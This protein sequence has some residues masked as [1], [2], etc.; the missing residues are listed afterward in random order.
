MRQ[1]LRAAVL[2]FVGIALC[3]DASA[4]VLGTI[5]GTAKDASGA[6]LPGV[7]VEVSS[8]ALI[9][10]VRT[11]VT[12]GS[13]LYRIVNLPPGTY[14]VVFTLTGFNTFRREGIQVS[15]GFTANIDGDMR[16]GNLQETVT[17][18]G[19]SPVVDIQSAAQTRAL[20]DQQFKE[21]PS[22][23]SWVQM[24]ALVPAI[25]AGNVD[26]G[27]VLGD[28]TGA[29]VE[30]HGSRPGDGVSM[31]DGLRIGNMY[32]SSNLT[33]MSLSPL[34]FDQVDVSL[35]GQ[36]AE[37]GTNGVIMN[38][39]PKAGGNRFSGTALANG[40]GPKLQGDNVS[41]DLNARGLTGASTTLKKL[42]DINGALGGPLKRDR[43][44][45]YVTSRYFT[46][47]Y[48]LASRFYPVDVTAINRA[49][50]TS[51]QAYAGTY[52]YDNNGRL[53]LAISDKQKVSGWYAYQYKVDPHWLLQLFQQS[54]EAAR[55]TTWHT[56]LSTTKW[57]YTATNRL[58]LEAGVSAGGSPD[59]IE[60]DTEQVGNCP[61]QGTLAPRCIA[62]VNQTI[63]FTHRAPTSFDFDDRLPSQTFSGSTSYVTGSHTAK[64]GFEWQRGHFWR[65]DHNEST[66]GI[67]YTVNQAADG[68]LIPAFVNLNAPATGWQDNL[69]ANLGIYAQDRWTI[70]RLTL[71]AGIRFD[72]LKSST[73][74]FTLGP[75]RWLPNRNVQF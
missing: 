56:Q 67:W 45:F 47:E 29:Q 64:I 66:G 21:L 6:I 48:Y 2:V 23:G 39:I 51:R 20:T 46:N 16:L 8:P 4:Q 14:T 25:R 7:T 71:S 35:S 1:A 42:Y 65:G 10:K 70:D 13:G 72:Y 37:T 36:M 58:L 52:T 57:T 11:A 62:I 68:T 41:A 55:V 43:L 40:S 24:A 49:N 5:T 9:E 30:A 28:Q 69:N 61:S 44:W 34:L 60:L 33:N 53:T 32:L 31:I 27:G 74:P 73:E 38:A 12:D 22:G 54:P 59:T 17:V 19:E 75:H 18:T 63:G 3:G 50:D 26:V 15:P